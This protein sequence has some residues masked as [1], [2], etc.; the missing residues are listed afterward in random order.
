SRWTAHY[1]T[2]DAQGISCFDR[3]NHAV[4]MIEDLGPS[5]E[6][7]PIATEQEIAALRSRHLMTDRPRRLP[8]LDRAMERER[9]AVCRAPGG[10]IAA[11]LDFGECAL[12]LR[13]LTTLK[14]ASIL[15]VADLDAL[16]RDGSLARVPGLGTKSLRAIDHALCVWAEARPKASERE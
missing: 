13:I 8:A 11:G 6:S 10:I 14:R 16:N 5:L 2:S 1:H 3:V 7:I 15:T 4:E 12:H 9:H